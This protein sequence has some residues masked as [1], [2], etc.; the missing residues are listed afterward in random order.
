MKLGNQIR[1]I[2]MV[3]LCLMMV[4]IVSG[5]ASV[6]TALADGVT[7]TIKS[8]MRGV[9]ADGTIRNAELME[10]VL[11][12]YGFHVVFYHIFSLEFRIIN[13]SDSLRS[14]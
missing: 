3:M 2:C 14:M 1:R 9:S 5:F 7:V 13:V 11:F 10:A 12:H 8:F 6:P 4:F